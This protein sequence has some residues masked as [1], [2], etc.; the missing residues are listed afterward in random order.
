MMRDPEPAAPQQPFGLPRPAEC[1]DSVR[2]W[3]GHSTVDPFGADSQIF[4]APENVAPLEV[5]TK[6]PSFCAS[7][8][9]SRIASAPLI[10]ND[11]VYQ[12]HRDGIFGELGDEVGR[13]ALHHVRTKV[14]V[15][16]RG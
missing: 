12:F 14:R 3:R 7:S 4:K 9:D 1:S 2:R 15:A 13:P 8:C 16:R 11:L 5:P 10:G 6:I